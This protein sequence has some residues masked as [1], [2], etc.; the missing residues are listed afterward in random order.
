MDQDSFRGPDDE[1]ADDEA[2]HDV[3]EK[4]SVRKNR[5]EASGCEAAQ[6]ISKIRPDDGGDRD[7]EEVL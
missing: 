4:R 5:S 7:G 6:Q 2:A 1:K 3:N